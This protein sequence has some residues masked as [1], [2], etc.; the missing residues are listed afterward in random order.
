MG[1]RQFKKRPFLPECAGDVCLLVPFPSCHFPPSSSHPFQHSAPKSRKT[2]QTQQQ[3][4]HKRRQKKKRKREKEGRKG[5]HKSAPRPP[6]PP[7]LW[8]EK[9]SWRGKCQINWINNSRLFF[10]SSFR[11]RKITR[12]LE[13]GSRKN[14]REN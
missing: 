2:E 4:S 6:P 8:K 13:I 10:V 5:C 12:E 9:R 14:Y 7:P 3:H 11:L 1:Q